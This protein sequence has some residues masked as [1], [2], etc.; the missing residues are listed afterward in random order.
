[1]DRRPLLFPALC[2]V[3]ALGVAG[4]S[5]APARVTAAT[6]AAPGTTAAPI[7]SPP[8]TA[9]APSRTRAPTTPSTPTPSTPAPTTSLR[10]TPT[11]TRSTAVSLAPFVDDW[12]GHTRWFLVRRTGRVVEHI[13]DGCCNPVIDL[14]LQLS[15]ARRTRTGWTA[16]ATVVSVTVHKGWRDGGRPPRRGQRGTVVIDRGVLT[17]SLTGATFCN[18]GS[19]QPSP[20]GA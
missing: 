18:A 11:P 19:G 4:C 5:A 9:A 1:M 12:Y 6:S 17:E 15:D 20:C 2:A 13:G 16:T 7:T 10:P 8:T 14:Q 3:L